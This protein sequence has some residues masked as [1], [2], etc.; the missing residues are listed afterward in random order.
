[1][2]LSTASLPIFISLRKDIN[3]SSLSG[4]FG[5]KGNLF[6]WFA[7]VLDFARGRTMYANAVT[8]NASSLS[9]RFGFMGILLFRFALVLDFARGCTMYEYVVTSDLMATSVGTSD[10][11]KRCH[12]RCIET[13]QLEEVPLHDFYAYQMKLIFD[14]HGDIVNQFFKH[15]I[16]TRRLRHSLIP[17]QVSLSTDVSLIVVNPS[18]GILLLVMGK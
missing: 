9:G 2:T 3:S 17:Y 1:M 18:I 10:V 5:L 13:T 11:C 12:L 4:R 7:L 14:L 15:G 16:I 8:S 6:I